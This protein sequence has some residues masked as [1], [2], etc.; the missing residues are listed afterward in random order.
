MIR[1]RFYANLDDYRPV[2]WPVKYPYWCSGESATNSIIVA[3]ADDLEYITKNWPEATDIDY[4]EV[5]RIVFT[6]R[7]ACPKWYKEGAE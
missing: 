7:F 5:D 3:Y 6:E 4:D 1:A 2:N